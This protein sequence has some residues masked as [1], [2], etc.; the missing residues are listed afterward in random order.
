MTQTY[1]EVAYDELVA[2]DDNVRQH[3]DTDRDK[4]LRQSLA[5]S[6]LLEPLV[7][8]PRDGK[9]LI[10]AGYRRY[11]QIGELIAG[12]SWTHLIPVVIREMT[13]DE[14]VA[15]MLI[16]NLQRVDLDPIEEATG[17]FKLVG[18]KWKQ[19]DIAKKIGRSKAHISKRLA[20]LALP[21]DVQAKVRSGEVTLD[22]AVLLA[23]ISDHPEVVSGLAN[24][25]YVDEFSIKQAKEDIKHQAQL[26]KITG[27]LDERQIP[28][29]KAGEVKNIDDYKKAGKVDVDKIDELLVGDGD[30]VVVEVSRWRD[31]PITLTHWSPLSERTLAERAKK[32]KD[33]KAEMRETAR[34]ERKVHA[35]QV[36]MLVETAKKMSKQVLAFLCLEFVL[37]HIYSN[38]LPELCKALGLERERD[39]ETG[40]FLTSYSAWEDAKNKWLAEAE[41]NKLALAGTKLLLHGYNNRRSSYGEDPIRDFVKQLLDEYDWDSVLVEPEAEDAAAG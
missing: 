3:S 34:K 6:G 9:Y 26:A 40:K 38:D 20:L 16:E 28:W 21:A 13:D 7:V 31:E 17:Y 4:E 33:D 15:A 1:A 32:V 5:E 8:T 23:Q 27:A 19:Q 10:V 36:D 41:K 11:T 12:G 29:H 2:A 24:K 14:R 18:M 25:R 22:A 30:F 35:A 39:A 37:Q